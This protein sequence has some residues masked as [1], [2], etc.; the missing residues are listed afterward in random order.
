MRYV[1]HDGWPGDEWS[2]PGP[3]EY[4]QALGVMSMRY[5][6]LELALEGVVRT[7]LQSIAEP[8]RD[9]LLRPLNNSQRSILLRRIANEVEARESV[10]DW[11][12]HFLQGFSVCAENRNIA[13]HATGYVGE[14]HFHFIKKKLGRHL[15]STSIPRVSLTSERYATACSI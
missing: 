14:I 1:G 3:E 5:N 13:L 12:H 2:E 9:Q 8:I 10:Q 4:L 7:Y 6:L 15:T 11:L